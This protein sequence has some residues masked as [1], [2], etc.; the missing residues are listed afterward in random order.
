MSIFQLSATGVR[1]INV[2]VT[3]NSPTAIV[4]ASAA[5]D[6]TTLFVPWFQVCEIN[7]GTQ[8]LTVEI[9]DGT[10]SRYLCD[11]A[12]NV[13]SGNAVTADKGYTFSQ[14]YILP[15]GSILRVTSGDASGYFHVHGVVGKPY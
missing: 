3:S 14:G 1:E 7:G 5:L 15:V 13:W 2:A 8:T 10:N 11:D 9:Y 12:G 6:D 4:D